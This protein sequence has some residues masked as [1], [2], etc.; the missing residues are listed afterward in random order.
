MQIFKAD[1]RKLS[2]S[3]QFVFVLLFL[4]LFAFRIYAN[5][6]TLRVDYTANVFRVGVVP[7]SDAKAWVEGA[8]QI[9]NGEPISG[10]AT[11]RPL[12]SLFLAVLFFLSGSSYMGAIYGQMIISALVLLAAYYLLKPIPNRVGVLLFMSFLAVWRPEVSTVFMTEN[13]GIYLLILSFALLWRGF[14]T[15]C[16]KTTLPGIFLL[17]LSQA[18]RPWCVMTLITVPFFSFASSKPIK[19]KLRSFL[20]HVLFI[21]LGF[22]LHSMAAGLFN[23]PGEGFAN[24]PQTLYGQVVGGKGWMAVDKDPVIKKALE[25]NLTAKAVNGIIYQRIKELFLENPGNLLKATIK[26][27]RYYFKKIPDEIGTGPKKPLFFVLFLLILGF[28]DISLRPHLFLQNLKRRPAAC[29]IIVFG[30]VLFFLKFSWFW[31]AFLL[32]GILHSIFNP[33]NRFNAFILLYL[34][35]ILLSIPLV[36]MDGG[37]RVKIGSNIVLFLVAATGMSRMIEKNRSASP[38]AKAASDYPV[39]YRLR[40]YHFLSILLGTAILFFGMPYFIN[41]VNDRPASSEAALRNINAE[42]ISARLNLSEIPIGPDRLNVLWHEWPKLTLEQKNGRMA[43]YPIR[44]TAQDTVFFDINEGIDRMYPA[45]AERHWPLIPLSMKRTVMILE[46]WYTL[47]TDIAPKDLKR[48]ENRE[49]IVVG[50]LISKPRRFLY[51]TPFVLYVSHII[52]I[53]ESG[54]LEVKVL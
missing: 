38:D 18:V 28:P 27:Y 12:Y 23:K 47:F 8:I 54:R 4:L 10:V 42:D 21:S 31:A 44:Y 34:I 51:A 20:L 16:E 17:G 15:R 9:I 50:K 14:S 48:Y 45:I 19:E 22:G 53:G 5:I 29:T 26:G 43:Y 39:A 30:V 13:L 36:G 2:P 1:H 40:T 6:G 7:W 41:H 49:I 3:P 24:N 33:K 25:K 46:R 37:M 32:A 35:G 11:A 52:S